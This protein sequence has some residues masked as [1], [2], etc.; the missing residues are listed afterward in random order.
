GALRADS[1]M[2]T[3]VYS[4]S[5]DRLGGEVLYEMLERGV[6][7]APVISDRGRLVGVLEAVDLYGAQPTSWFGAR[8]AI[9]RVRTLDAISQA[10]ARLPELMLDLHHS[11]VPALELAPVLSALVDALTRRALEL[12]T[13]TAQ[14]LPNGVVWVALGS[15]ARRE[16]TPASVKRGAIIHAGGEPPPAQWLEAARDAVTRCGIIGPVIARDGESWTAAAGS[17]EL[18]LSVLADR[19]VL[20]GNPVDPLPV[21]EGSHREALLRGLA[22]QAFAL[23]PPTGF[24]TDAVLTTDGRHSRLNI[25]DAAILPIAAIARWAAVRSGTEEV[26]TPER[27]QVAADAGVLSEDQAR[28]L[29]EAFDL[30]LEL[31]I[32]HQLEQVEAGQPPDDLLNAAT[33]SPLTRDRL[34]DVF[35][36]VSAVQRELRPA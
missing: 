4:V 22:E 10:A 28:T 5:A 15:L 12:V 14:P 26:S 8:R 9:E 16:L 30:V 19:R 34:R 35:R 32:A 25:R 23:R 13:G 1:V 36:A 7:H 21:A 2:T 3:P 29:S 20:W 11:S 31:R 27:L 18:A 6:R 33:M 24:D 17:D